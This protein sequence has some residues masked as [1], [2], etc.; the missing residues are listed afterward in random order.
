[1]ALIDQLRHEPVEQGQQQGGDMGAVHIGVSH[2]HDLVVT[3]FGDVKIIAVAFGKTAAEGIDHGLDLSV[4]QDLVYAGLLYI[5]DLAPDGQDGL[6]HTVP[7]H[8]GGTARGITLDNE[9]LTFGGVPAGTVGQLAVGV[10]GE[11]LLCQDIDLGLLLRFTDFGGFFGTADHR[12]KDI[13]V[14]VKEADDLLTCHRA[15]RFGRVG[16]IQLG[17]GL[18]LKAGIRMLDGD[19][20]CHA[21]ADIG[22][23]K[24]AVLLLQAAQLAGVAVQDLGK[25][26]LETCQVGAALRI[27]DIVA[28]AQDIFVILVDI[29]EGAFHCDPFRF[30]LEGDNVRDRFLG[31]IHL[32]DETDDA[33]GFMEGLC[34]RGLRPP[35]LIDDGQGRVQIGRLVQAALDILLP[36]TGLFK[37]LGIG[38]EIDPGPG[39][40]SPDLSHDRQQAVLQFCD[41]DAPFI[42]ILIDQSALGY[43]N[44][45]AFGQGIDDRRAHAVQ[46]AAGL[47][48][49]VVKFAAGMERSEND[50]LGADAQFVHTDRDAASVVRYRTGPVRFQ[51]DGDRIAEARQV[52]VHRV[53]HDLID[54]VIQSPGGYRADIHARPGP[55]RFQAFQDPDAARVVSVTARRGAGACRPS[56]IH[57]GI[58]F[59][60]IWHRSVTSSISV[61][62]GPSDGSGNVKI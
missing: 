18:A 21:V 47:V 12:T 40:F 57:R 34:L 2:D 30:S 9:D 55:D 1:M 14:A 16:I 22:T 60:F 50:T 54:Q 43:L 13:Q 49:I 53:V 44:G 52:F 3:Q 48:G 8:L 51:C 15:D 23:G 33:V 45:Q 39:L 31:F 62:A 10:K 4:G 59:L 32:A 19:D 6:V 28:E 41:R 58:L 56:G 11:L 35:V 61:S 5:K 17:L 36:E 29:L 26:G 46:A 27:I 37:D 7:G 38:Q 24:I 42:G 25:C 20:R